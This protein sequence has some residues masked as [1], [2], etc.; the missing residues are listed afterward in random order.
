MA[1]GGKQPK[2]RIYA[3]TSE[4]TVTKSD[5]SLGATQASLNKQ[6]S[7]A[8][9]ANAVN[10]THDTSKGATTA[11]E[12]AAAHAQAEKDAAADKN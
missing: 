3:L 6:A 10:A 12:I 1:R 9:L 4:V 8:S 11:A 5:T 7:D 2:E